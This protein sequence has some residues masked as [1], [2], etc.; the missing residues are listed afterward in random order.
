MTVDIKDKLYKSISDYCKINHL[1][2]KD[3]INDL[4]KKS[5]MIDKYGEQPPISGEIK[6]KNEPEKD[7]GVKTIVVDTNKPVEVEIEVN[8]NVETKE[9]EVEMKE[10]TIPILPI[11]TKEVVPTPEPEEED[12]EPKIIVEKSKKRKLK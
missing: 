11:E 4:L 8:K 10:T 6:V 5:F 3:Y 2:I 7:D 12:E 9:Y 1:V